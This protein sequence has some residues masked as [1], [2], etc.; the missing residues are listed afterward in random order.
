MHGTQ[1]THP[2]RGGGWGAGLSEY[3]GNMYKHVGFCTNY[4]RNV[5][6]TRHN[7]PAVCR[8]RPGVVQP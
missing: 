6:S 4:S 5:P 8:A 3:G 1:G 2:G 7:E